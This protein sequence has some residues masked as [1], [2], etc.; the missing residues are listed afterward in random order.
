MELLLQFLFAYVDESFSYISLSFSNQHERPEAEVVGK[1]QKDYVSC[2]C[3]NINQFI[4][5][6]LLRYDLLLYFP[7]T[8]LHL[9]YNLTIMISWFPYLILQTIS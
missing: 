9:Y 5:T 6:L 4:W 3:L 7:Y 1:I 8:T 2:K